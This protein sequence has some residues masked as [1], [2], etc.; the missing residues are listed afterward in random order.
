MFNTVKAIIREVLQRQKL[1]DWEEEIIVVTYGCEER[2]GVTKMTIHEE[3]KQNSNFKRRKE[4]ELQ[5][6]WLWIRDFDVEDEYFLF[7]KR[8]E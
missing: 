1:E 5:S 8:D 4:E 3:R 6:W 2:K 7:L